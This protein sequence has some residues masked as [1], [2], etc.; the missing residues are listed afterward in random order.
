VITTGDKNK[1]YAG[2][3]NFTIRKLVNWKKKSTSLSEK[4]Q[5]LLKAVTHRKNKQTNSGT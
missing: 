5:H 3:V 4:H 2:S 1:K